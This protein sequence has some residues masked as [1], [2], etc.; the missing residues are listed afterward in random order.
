[1]AFI[2]RIKDEVNG[3]FEDLNLVNTNLLLIDCSKVLFALFS[4]NYIRLFERIMSLRV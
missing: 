2:N 3:T 1:M 4:S